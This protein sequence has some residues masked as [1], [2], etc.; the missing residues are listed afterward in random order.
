VK[1]SYK[2]C[3]S[4]AN[5][6]GVLHIDSTVLKDKVYLND[7]RIQLEKARVSQMKDNTGSEYHS[8]QYPNSNMIIR[9][10]TSYKLF[11]GH[12]SRLGHYY[13]NLFMMVKFVAEQE[14]PLLSY[15]DKREY[16]RILRA[17]ISTDEQLMLYFN[18]ISEYG[19][20]WE[21]DENKFFSNYRMIHNL[22]ME[23]TRFASNPRKVFEKEI[24]A[25]KLTGERMFEY[26]ED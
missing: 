6:A 17:Q 8:Y 13:R 22:P 2:L 18:Y 19:R 14:L 3:F 26:D 5:N 15:R 20:K 21:N 16:L 11:S 4:G 23:L 12:V 25:V 24:A 10:P 1:A 7:F 9:L